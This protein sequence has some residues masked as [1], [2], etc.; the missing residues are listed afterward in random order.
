MAA[1]MAEAGSIRQG[2][3]MVLGSAVM[4]PRVR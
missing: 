3:E 1:I 4:D 2:M